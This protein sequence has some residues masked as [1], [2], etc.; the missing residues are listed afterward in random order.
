MRDAFRT[1]LLKNVDRPGFCLLTGDLGFGL[2]EPL[3]AA[4]GPRFINAG[5]AEQNMVSV[6]AGMA[7][8]GLRPWVY[9]I[10][11]FLYARAF[12]QIR[13]D[14]VHHRLP[15]VLVGNG[16]GYGYGV[17]GSTHHSLD[18]YGALAALDGL[19][20][21]VPCLAA[22]LAP[23][24]Q[25]LMSRPRPVYLRLGKCERP[26]TPTPAAFAPWRKL[27]DGGN[28]V[29]VS[30][31]PLAAT[32]LDAL[33]DE[34]EG[35]R[36]SLWVVGSLPVA[37]AAIPPEF[38]AQVER[39]KLTVVEEHVAPGGLAAMLALSLAELGRS[40]LQLL[41]RFARRY[42]SGRFGSQTF[43]RRES[44]LDAASVLAALREASP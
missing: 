23:I 32:L 42:P 39:S 11:P 27:L 14:V 16:G 22:D 34:P 3:A 29:L 6:A 21:I 7:Q 35:R 12:E 19:E 4:L 18:D 10:G 36:P 9:S 26:R 2:F 41:H 28:G 8:E 13:N 24:V 15:V 17:M 33:A 30:V 5:V 1:E 20:I 40:P 25:D 43:H 31:G 38:L 37:T 44:G